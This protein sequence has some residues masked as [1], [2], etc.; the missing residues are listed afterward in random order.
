ME[1]LLHCEHHASAWGINVGGEVTC[2]VILGKPYEIPFIHHLVLER[3]RN[4]TL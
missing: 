4:G 1:R 3:G 2:E